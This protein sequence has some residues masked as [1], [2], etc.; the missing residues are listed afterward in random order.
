MHQLW[1]HRNDAL[2]N[3][4]SIN[5]LSGL[6]QRKTSITTEI[7]IR[8]DKLSMVYS[9]YFKIPL[10][11][12]LGKLFAYLKRWFLMIRSDRE[13]LSIRVDM[14]VFSFDGVLRSLI[15]LFPLQ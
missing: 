10:A 15:G 14:G 9:L 12:L 8:L 1:K 6:D 2:H 7:E 11:R 4:E 5:L 13:A 3:S